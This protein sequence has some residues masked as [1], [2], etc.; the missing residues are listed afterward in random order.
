MSR[1]ANVRARFQN[2]L[3]RLLPVIVAVFCCTQP[4]ARAQTAPTVLTNAADVLSLSPAQAR[5]KLPVFVR[6]VVTAAEPTWRGQFFLQ[7]ETSGVFV[8]NIADDHP[9]PGDLVEVKGYTQPGAFAPVISKPA[10]SVLGT[11]PLPK[12]KRVSLEQLM[13]GLEDGQRVEIGGIV[14]AIT[15]LTWAQDIQITSGGNRIHIFRKRPSDGDPQNLIGARVRARGVVAASFNKEA[16]LRHLMSVVMF[17]TT[18]NDFVVEQLESKNPFDKE[19]I[20]LSGVGEY[21]RDIQPGQRVHLKGVVTLQRPGED[22]FLQDTNSGLQVRTRQADKLQVGDVVDVVG[23]PDLDHFLPVLDDALFRKTSESRV[24]AVPKKT[25]IGEI[26]IGRHHADLVTLQAKLLERTVRQSQTTLG[27]SAIALLLQADDGLAFT[28]EGEVPEGNDQLTS[29]PIGSTV[30]ITGVCFTQSGEDQKLHSLQLLLADS[31]TVRI[32]RRASWFTPQRLLVGVAILFAVLVVAV[33]WSVTVSKKNSVLRELIHDREAAQLALQHAHDQLED[34]VKERTAQLKFQITARKESELQFKAILKERTRLAQ[35]LHDTVEQTLTGIALQLD[36]TS[37]LFDARPEGASHH[38][39]LAR[40]LVSQSQVDVR[41]SVWDLRSRALEQFDLPGALSTSCKQ[42]I[43]GTN[44]DL[45]VT[46]KGRVRPLS[47]TIE[48]NLL[49]I[50]QEALTN[51]IKHS[52][53]TAASIELDYGAQNVMLEI[54]DNGRGFE[55]EKSAGPSEGHFG[56]LGISERAKRLGGELSVSSEIGR[57]TKV[58]VQ[59]PIEQNSPSPDFAASE[60]VI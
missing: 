45:E 11:A 14:R 15:S 21:R 20:P 19:I 47:E 8:E 59:V 39:E 17:V 3:L 5:K 7:D 12:A 35:E 38:L 40:N 28:A 34:R 27:S 18:T 36:T 43:D 56:L 58:R 9:E 13:S 10:W 48:E 25:S 51:V 60:A 52:G 4:A 55:Q 16:A 23:F 41:R 32:L 50:A 44:I 2:R 42:L 33:S 30:E 29:I 31:S 57:G 53:A 6:G 54:Q 1:Q 49:R 22:L 46:A 24:P 26:Q 37:K